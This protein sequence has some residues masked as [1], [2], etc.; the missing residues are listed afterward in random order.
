MFS[1]SLAALVLAAAAVVSGP[2]LAAGDAAQGEKVFRKCRVCH[3][4]DEEKNQVGPHLVGL[5]GSTSGSIEDYKYSEAM[6]EAAI[7]W[8]EASLTA[9]LENPR[10]YVKGTKMAFGGLKKEQD[11]KDISAYLKDATTPQ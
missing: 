7:T 10:G 4:V 11:L 8:D 6:I 3:A 1:G 5:F 9:Y 2:A